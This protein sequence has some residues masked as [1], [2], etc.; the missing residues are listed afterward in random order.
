MT[1]I[2]A[3]RPSAPL[4]RPAGEGQHEAA[5]A[6]SGPTLAPRPS[7]LVSPQFQTTAIWIYRCL[8]LAGVLT[9]AL[10]RFEQHYVPRELFTSEIRR[11]EQKLD[12]LIA[13]RQRPRM[14]T[15]ADSGPVAF[16]G[17]TA[18][19]PPAAEPRP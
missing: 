9:A 18:A 16:S 5:T 6:V 17:S 11:I 7:P 13:D 12:I 15:R 19:R 1:S 4:A 3:L 2:D 8:V 10:G 14:D